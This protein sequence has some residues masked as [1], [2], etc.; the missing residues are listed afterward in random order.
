MKSRILKELNE[1]KDYISGQDLCDKLGVSRTAIW[2]HIKALK[3]EGYEIDSVTNKGYRLVSSPDIISQDAIAGNLETKWLGN[4]IVYK[5]SMDSTNM[6][7]RRLAEEKASH[8]TLAICEEQTLGRGRRGRDWLGEPRQG[9]WMSFL[10]RPDIAVENSPMITIITALSVEEAIVKETGIQGA[11]KWPNDVVVHGKKVCGILTE[12][13]AQMD[14]IT[15][16]I[17]GVGINVAQKAFPKDLRDKAT[18]LYLEGAKE[19][20]RSSLAAKVLEVFEAK[21]EK[22]LET[23]DLRAF[24]EEYNSL[25]V[26]TNQRIRVIRG[27]KEEEF[28]SRGI[29]ERGELVVEDDAGSLDVVFSGEVSVRGILGYV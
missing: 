6:E 21:Y 16:V 3:E 7:I 27:D 29:N 10:L 20:N 22:Y 14:E 13:S 24:V 4:H 1:A 15:Y 11:I 17:A 8:G 2:K 23:E 9:I 26:H 18:S 25:M 19:V 28:I 12:L 5:D